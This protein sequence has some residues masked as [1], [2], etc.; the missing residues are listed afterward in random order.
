MTRLSVQIIT[1]T[2][3][4][5]SLEY[6]WNALLSCSASDNIFLRWE[7]LCNWWNFFGETSDRLYILLVKQG[8]DVRGI[9]PFYIKQEKQ[10]GFLAQRT[11]LFLGSGEREEEEVLSEY[12]DIICRAGEEEKVIQHLMAF[13]LNEDV[14]DEIRLSHILADSKTVPILK[15]VCK[16]KR[17]PFYNAFNIDCPFIPLP[18]DWETYLQAISPSMRYEIRSDRRRLEKM[19]VVLMKKTTRLEDFKDHFLELVRLHNI[20]WAS[21]GIQ[22]A[23]E[24]PKFVLFHQ[25][26]MPILLKNGHLQ[27]WFLSLSS[28]NIATSYNIQYNNKVYF[29]QTGLDISATPKVSGG[30]VLRSYCIEEAICSKREEYDLMGGGGM[31]SYKGRWADNCRIMGEIN[32]PIS[33]PSR[34]FHILQNIGKAIKRKFRK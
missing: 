17:L 29:Y 21:Q 8:E 2:E 24:Y 30:L 1:S 26:V 10:C 6:E 16:E 19:G 33:L 12:L 18:S 15:Q 14:C 27:L 13:I 22:G 11:L 32:V 25:T 20:R 23:F 34:G 28:K 5:A 31:K 9:A 7:W 4:F 3:E